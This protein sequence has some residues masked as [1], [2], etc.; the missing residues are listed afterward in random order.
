MG[1][2]FSGNLRKIAKPSSNY[3]P[4]LGQWARVGSKTFYFLLINFY[5]SIFLAAEISLAHWRAA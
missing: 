2:R 1:D 4:N 5:P 3:L